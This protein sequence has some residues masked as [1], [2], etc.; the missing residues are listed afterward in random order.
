MKNLDIYLQLRHFDFWYC[1]YD[2]AEQTGWEDVILSKKVE[3]I[4]RFT[5]CSA[6]HFESEY[7][8]SAEDY[9]AGSKYVEKVD[10]YYFFYEYCNCDRTHEYFYEVPFEARKNKA[11]I[12]P[13]YIEVWHPAP[14]IDLEVLQDSVREFCHKFLKI[15]PQQII[16]QEKYSLEETVNEFLKNHEELQDR[17]FTDRL[18]QQLAKEWNKTDE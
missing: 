2:L 12:K 10:G 5:L 8:D 4:G 7:Q 13:F 16:F 18:V 1:Y 3:E 6:N 15:N 14:G 11:G 9:A 17:I